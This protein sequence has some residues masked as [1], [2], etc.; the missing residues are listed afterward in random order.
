MK[1]RVEF[2]F[3]RI[4]FACRKS[5][6]ILEAFWL[7]LEVMEGV[8]NLERH[9]LKLKIFNYQVSSYFH[10]A[11]IMLWDAIHLSTVCTST[12]LITNLAN[13]FHKSRNRDR[14]ILE[15]QE[16]VVALLTTQCFSRLPSAILNDDIKALYFVHSMVTDLLFCLN[17]FTRFHSYISLTK[18]N[19]RKVQRT[20]INI[21]CYIS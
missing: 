9:D 12:I 2:I 8:V 14:S 6:A 15:I 3:Y 1:G 18:K 7:L 16:V 11:K 5:F 19:R 4:S 20:T 10:W 21:I 17:I 13:I